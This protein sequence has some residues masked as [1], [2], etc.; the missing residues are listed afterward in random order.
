MGGKAG[1]LIRKHDHFVPEREIGRDIGAIKQSINHPEER[2]I[3]WRAAPSR[4]HYLRTK[5][6][7]NCRDKAEPRQCRAIPQ[8]TGR[9]GT[10]AGPFRSFSFFELPT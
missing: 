8:P 1:S 3:L 10:E 5:V 7:T 4:H 9:W 2:F 6:R